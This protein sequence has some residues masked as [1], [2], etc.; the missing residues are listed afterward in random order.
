MD[1][2]TWGPPIAVLVVGVVAGV[3]VALQASD[4]TVQSDEDQDLRARHAQLL[5]QL[6]ALQVDEA[7]LGPAEYARQREELV[8]EAASVLRRLEG[9]AE[10][11]PLP[12]VAKPSIG[13]AVFWIVATLAF[14]GAAAAI[15]VQTAKPR[16][17]EPGS[18][19][20]MQAAAA[21]AEKE[22][23]DAQA[24]LET[25]PQHLESLNV[26]GHHAIMNQQLQEAMQ[27][28]DQARAVDGD[29]PH[30]V[31]HLGALQL[32]VGMHG[33]AEESFAQAVAGNG[34]L[35]EA[36]IW[37]GVSLAQQGD[38]EGAKAKLQQAL[39]VATRAQD[40]AAAHSL[41]TDLEKMSAPAAF[42][43]VVQLAE[44]VE[45]DKGVLYVYARS[46]EVA[47]GPPLAALRLPRWELPQAF[48]LTDG[49]LLPMAG[50]Q[51]PE[52]VWVSARLD[53]D[54]DPATDSPDDLTAVPLGP[55]P[56][57]SGELT[58]VLGGEAPAE[59]GAEGEDAEAAAP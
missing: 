56:S 45:A 5:E 34:S 11:A 36:W 39:Q 43:G 28:V 6:R 48:V 27:Y 17:D 7:R 8:R 22:L 55:M 59:E 51:W 29:D 24:T 53:V 38:A 9:T 33:K 10:A 52:Q 58:I 3:L 15:L 20:P 35:A 49:D 42:T 41:L 47:A 21:E 26:M 2:E 23:A 50:G 32:L 19:G 31:T 57:G 13:K 40:Q 30:V 44:G 54:G 12:T 18:M 25:D 1:W 16:Q 37:W 4:G 14:F 46:S